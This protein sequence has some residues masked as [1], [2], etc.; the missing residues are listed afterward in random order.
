MTIDRYF[1]EI[2]PKHAEWNNEFAIIIIAVKTE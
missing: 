2:F 1:S